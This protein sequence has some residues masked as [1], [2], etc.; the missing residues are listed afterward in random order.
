M[1]GA[2]TV[3][4]QSKIIA[5]LEELK[6]EKVSLEIVWCPESYYSRGNPAKRNS[7]DR[8]R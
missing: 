6:I 8:R 4:K 5:L 7:R 3:E 2:K 1:V